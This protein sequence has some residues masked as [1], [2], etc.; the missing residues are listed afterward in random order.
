[1][2]IEAALLDGALVPITRCP[3]CGESPF[4]P[5]MRGQVQRPTRR[6]WFWPFGDLRPT[7]ALICWRCKEIV[8]WE[9]A[10]DGS[11]PHAE[12]RS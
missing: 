1:M 9:W 2:P 11:L 7:C 5:F 6:L 8:G 3:I 4:R 10:P 12:L